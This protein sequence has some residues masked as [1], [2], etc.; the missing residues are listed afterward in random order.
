MSPNG[1]LFSPEGYAIFTQKSGDQEKGVYLDFDDCNRHANIEEDAYTVGTYK[2]T[3]LKLSPKYTIT[4][5]DKVTRE[6]EK[7][8]YLYR[9]L[10]ANKTF[11]VVREAMTNCNT[12][13]RDR[14]F[15][16]DYE[17]KDRN[18]TL[19][20][21]ELMDG[22]PKSE[23]HYARKLIKTEKKKITLKK[24]RLDLK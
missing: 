14:V 10:E 8:T 3:D 18:Y 13:Y 11:K 12:S 1:F 9:D 20:G 24:Y 19:D 7:N 17:Y 15:T 22:L 6:E 23:S 2:P 5:I 4:P 21:F 16:Q